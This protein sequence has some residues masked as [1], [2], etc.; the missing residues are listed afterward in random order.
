MKQRSLF[1]KEYFPIG[2]DPESDGLG[3]KGRTLIV[4]TAAPRITAR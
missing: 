4:N 3:V 1:E 2:S